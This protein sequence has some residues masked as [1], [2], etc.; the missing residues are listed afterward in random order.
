HVLQDQILGMISSAAITTFTHSNPGN[1]YVKSAD[2]ISSE[3]R[4]LFESVARIIIHDSEGTLSEQIN[5]HKAERI[6]PPLLELKSI[7]P[8]ESE[9]KQEVALPNDL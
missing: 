3:D 4:I 1:V 5:R 2:Q 6:L 9:I 7:I 8:Q